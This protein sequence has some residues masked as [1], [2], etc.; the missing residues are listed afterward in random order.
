VRARR[1]GLIRVAREIEEHI[2]GVLIDRAFYLHGPD[3]QRL[4]DDLGRLRVDLHSEAS[5]RLLTTL[6]VLADAGTVPTIAAVA[7]QSGVPAAH[8]DRILEEV[9]AGLIV[10]LDGLYDDLLDV[11][12]R[13]ELESLGRVLVRIADE[14]GSWD[15]VAVAEAVIPFVEMVVGCVCH[16]SASRH[17]C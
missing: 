15:V 4:R 8:V 7:R 11:R 1:E 5:R 10:D 2:V 6:R 13:V 9:N 17:P 16:E 14:A 12:R 3:V